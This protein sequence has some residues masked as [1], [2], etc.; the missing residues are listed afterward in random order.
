MGFAYDTSTI[1]IPMPNVTF[2]SNINKCENCIK[3]DVCKYKEK[4]EKT[5]NLADNW[6]KNNSESRDEYDELTEII[7]VNI[8]CK[9]FNCNN[10]TEVSIRG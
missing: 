5:N 2:P 4:F 3:E 6:L 8:R 7:E 9:K 10:Y 1:N